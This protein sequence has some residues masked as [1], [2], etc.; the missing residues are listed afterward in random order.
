[1]RLAQ[2]HRQ[3]HFKLTDAKISFS[4]NHV[5]V[6]TASSHTVLTVRDV[7]VHDGVVTRTTAVR[8][9]TTSTIFALIR[10]SERAP[11]CRRALHQSGW[12]EGREPTRISTPAS[13]SRLSIGED[14]RRNPLTDYDQNGWMLGRDP[15]LS[16][17]PT[18]ISPPIR[19][20]GRAYRSAGPFFSSTARLRAPGLSGDL[21]ACA[22]RPSTTP[23]Y[24]QHN[25][26]VAAAG[27]DAL[28]TSEFRWKE[29]RNAMPY[30]TPPISAHYTGRGV[31]RI[32]PFDHYNASGWQEGRDPSVNLRL[33][34]PTWRPI[35]TSPMRISIRSCT[36][37][38]RPR[39]R[40]LILAEGTW[41]T[42][43]GDNADRDA[44]DSAAVLRLH[45]AGRPRMSAESPSPARA[46]AVELR[47]GYV[48][49][50]T[51]LALLALRR[52]GD[53]QLR[54]VRRRGSYA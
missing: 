11:R 13:T 7:R 19:C 14:G 16:S 21:A 28:G 8:W 26:D 10:M 53:G 34:N 42:E 41:I 45:L 25:P 31:G 2:R 40:P 3:F 36:S 44:L 29:G 39:R 12:H 5:T 51:F 18:N 38:T 32:N 30:S 1:M 50:C 49:A 37:R 48:D 33:P 24:L 22:E 9:S 35:R 52:A 43:L 23:N 47:A 46:G 17:I 4:G 54:G 20:G 27:V 15:S 6:D